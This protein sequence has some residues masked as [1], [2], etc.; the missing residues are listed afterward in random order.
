MVALV[1]YLLLPVTTRVG[2]PMAVQGQPAA[3]IESALTRFQDENAIPGL[4]FTVSCEGK[5][6]YTFQRGYA[7]RERRTP[8]TTLTRVA[9]GSIS[10]TATALAVMHLLTA[11]NI[12]LDAPA[13]PYLKLT[14]VQAKKQVAS[15]DYP[16]ITFRDLLQHSAGFGPAFNAWSRPEVAKAFEG[17][18]PSTARQNV[19]FGLRQPLSY[20][21]GTKAELSNFGYVLLGRLIE[22]ISGT[23]YR[24]YVQSTVFGPLGISRAVLRRSRGPENYQDEA[25]YYE[26]PEHTYPSVFAADHGKGVALMYGGAA[27]EQAD[28]AAGWVSD[29]IDLARLVSAFR[30]DKAA[31]VLSD[32]MQMEII[33]RP[34]FAGSVAQYKGLGLDVELGQGAVAFREGGALPGGGG[35]FSTNFAGVCMTLVINKG[36]D[37]RQLPW[38]IHQELMSAITAI[39]W[40]QRKSILAL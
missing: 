29:S 24:E 7:D 15:D 21:P 27:Y 5:L 11:K 14:D 32:R 26:Q 36:I 40:S 20:V 13:L 4:C 34:E 10:R 31:Q 9:L 25:K 33:R 39:D 12:S 3:A 2:V 16:K 18:M 23:P 17:T 38:E 28:A 35:F 6:K 22:D 30:T 37:G 1:A 19:V 8:F